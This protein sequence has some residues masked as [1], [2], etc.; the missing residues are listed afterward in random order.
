VTGDDR[1]ASRVQFTGY[2]TD[3]PRLLSAV[4]LVAH[5]SHADALPTALI[6]A[7]AAGVPVVAT[8]VGGIPEVLGV[9]AGILQPPGRPDLLSDALLGLA[10]DATRRG[11]MGDAGR[12][13]YAEQFAA[14]LWAR[15]LGS[16]YAELLAESAL[17]R[18]R[19]G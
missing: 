11:A 19:S 7:M 10:A 15:R 8:S 3:V 5:P 18:R 12:Q 17:A 6:H 16:L 13:R 9:E 1:L 2:R 4:D 14:D